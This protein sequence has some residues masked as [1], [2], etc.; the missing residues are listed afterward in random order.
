MIHVANW[1]PHSMM[2]FALL[3]HDGLFGKT[4]PESCELTEDEI[5]NFSCVAWQNSGM[6]SRTE[7]WTLSTS[8]HHND[9]EES[10]LSDILEKTGSVPQQCYL[11]I[12]QIDRL[13]ARL[14]KY[15]GEENI[16]LRALLKCSAGLATKRRSMELK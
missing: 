10:L 8:E 6:G 16:L 7:F 5:S 1:Q 4:S 9:A 13:I 12:K 2:L 14:R 11:S 3:H 15:C